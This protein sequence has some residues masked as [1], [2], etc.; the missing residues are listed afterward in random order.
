MTPLRKRMLEELQRR[1]YSPLTIQSYVHAVEDFARYFGR[2]PDQ[3]NEEHMREY[4]LHLVHDR[5]LATNTII[6]RIAALRFLFVKT[7]RRPYVQVDLPRPKTE[8]RLPTVL[9]LESGD[10]DRGKTEVEAIHLVPAMLDTL[11]DYE[12]Y[13]KNR[14]HL[15]PSTLDRRTTELTIFLDFLHSRKARTL[16]EIQALDL[17]EFVSW[18]DHLKPTTVSRIVSDVGSFLK[19]LTM[20]GI[21]E[22]DL[23]VGLPKIRVA[24]DATIPS[25]WEQELVVRLLQAVDRSSAKGKRD[26][27]I[28]LL[29]C[30]LG[31]RVGDIR[32]LKLDQIHW[33]DS[34]IEVTQSK[35]GAP[36]RLPLTNEVGEALTQQYRITV[37]RQFSTFL[38]RAGDPAYVPDSTLTAGN[39]S[40]FVPRMLTDEELRKFFH[41]VDALEPTARSPLRH[42]VMPEVFRLLYGCGFRVREVLK[43]RVRDVDLNQ[44]IITVHQGKFRKD[45]LVPPA[46]SLV[47]RLRKY[48]GHFENRP[49]DAIF[50]PGPSGGPFALRTVYTLFRKLLLRC[51]IPHAGR[52][53]GPRIH[54]YRHLFACPTLRRWYR[55]GED[56]DAKLPLLATY[57]G[58]QHL[59]GTQRYLHLTAEIF[60]EITVR[61]DAAFGDVIPRRIER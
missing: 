41:A 4:H 39:P 53:K 13:C 37:V 51:G 23:S 47:N 59:A 5:K 32:T 36:L 17:S 11:H 2:S 42:L 7:L 46:L 44:G 6:A 45:R 35:T 31:M 19:F 16:H 60:P 61:V 58:H 12:E 28:L 52:G 14:L 18:R 49:P 50:F 29:A 10:M 34:T 30:R 20:R 3:L 22:K 21:I 8:K 27:A 40:T 55:D 54:D 25:I 57:L 43:L 56:L 24:R 1:N 9:S 33:E 15:R 38:L 26:Y 48:S